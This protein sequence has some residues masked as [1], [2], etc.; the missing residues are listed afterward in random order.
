VGEGCKSLTHPT[1]CWVW[2]GTQ[3][4]PTNNR[5]LG[6]GR[7]PLSFSNINRIFFVGGGMRIP[8]HLFQRDLSV[9]RHPASSTNNRFCFLR[10]RVPLFLPQNPFDLRMGRDR[11]S[12][13]HPFPLQNFFDFGKG[14]GFASLHPNLFPPINK[15]IWEWGGIANPSTH[16]FPTPNFIRFCGEFPFF[17]TEVG[18]NLDPP[19]TKTF[20]RDS[21]PFPPKFFFIFVWASSDANRPQKVRNSFLPSTAPN[22]C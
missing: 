10:G 19:K 9:G 5:F 17:S 15:S 2:G 6:R 7:V 11:E 21:V 22:F 12:L 1:T 8:H 20:S 18:R 3:P 16:P 13:Y 4:L 14:V